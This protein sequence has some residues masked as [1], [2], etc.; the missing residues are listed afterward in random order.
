LAGKVIS[1]NC[2]IDRKSN[3]RF[4]RART[5]ERTLSGVSV[6]SKK[7]NVENEISQ[8]ANI[9]NKEL[10]LRDTGFSS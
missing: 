5:R 4:L 3:L 2:F 6:N 1:I 7:I 10:I 9:I 8:I